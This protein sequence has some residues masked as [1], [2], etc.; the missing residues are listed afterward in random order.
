MAL[1]Q[2]KQFQEVAMGQENPAVNPQFLPFGHSTV[3]LGEV[4][5]AVGFLHQEEHGPGNI[6]AQLC[7]IGTD[8]LGTPGAA[9]V[10]E[11]H[12]E[13]HQMFRVNVVGGVLHQGII[14]A[15]LMFQHG[16]GSPEKPAL[17]TPIRKMQS[18]VHH[19]PDASFGVVLESFEGLAD[20][21]FDQNAG[22]TVF[23]RVGSFLVNCVMFT[24]KKFSILCLYE[25]WTF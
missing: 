19:I 2:R 24:R 22:H 15:V 3:V 25:Q 11:I 1:D 16:L 8:A 21:G 14:G 4:S 13:S 20:C 12:A 9:V 18:H 10:A 23:H 5:G 6:E 17:E 7:L